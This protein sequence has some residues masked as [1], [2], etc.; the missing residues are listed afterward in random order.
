M[1]LKD[2]FDGSSGLLK[3]DQELGSSLIEFALCLPPLLIVLF[4]ICSFGLAM[5]NYITLTEATSVSARQVA[6]SRQQT[7]DPCSTAS[8][9]FIAASPLLNSS[10]LTF[11]YSF[12]G[13]AASG[14][15]CPSAAINLKQ[16]T[17]AM[18]NV[19]YP[20]SLSAYTWKFGSACNLYAQTTEVVQ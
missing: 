8:T 4:G 10:K 15:S 1:L 13:V 11:S 7:I 16:G 5:N 2:L 9:A 3:D 17:A 6:I 12:N 18:V 20:C 19:S 14:T